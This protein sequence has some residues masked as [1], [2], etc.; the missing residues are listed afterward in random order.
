MSEDQQS[1]DMSEPGSMKNAIKRLES[2]PRPQLES[3][4]KA[5][6]RAMVM[7][8]ARKQDFAPQPL[9]PNFNVIVRWA[10]VASLVLFVMSATGVSA[11]L[12]SV[13]GDVLYPLKQRFEQLELSFTSTAGARAMQH[14]T[15]AQR[16]VDEVQILLQ[17]EQDVESTAFGVLDHLIQAAIIANNDNTISAEDQGKMLILTTD[18]TNQLNTLLNDSGSNTLLESVLATENSGTLLLAT[19]TP[20]ATPTSTDSPTPTAMP[21]NTATPTETS[22]HTPTASPS[23]T[24]EVSVFIEGRI[25]AI[26][27]NIIVIYGIDHPV[28]PNNPLLDSIEIGDYVRITGDDLELIVTETPVAN[29][30][31]PDPII[32]DENA[33]NGEQNATGWTDDGSCNNPPPDHAPAHG[34]RARCEGQASPG[35]SGNQGQGNGGNNNGNGQGNNGNNGRGNPN[36]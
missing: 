22:T 32:A 4:K 2:A 21:T 36:K 23:P 18:L 6:I 17:R 9:R 7:A 30:V 28:N 16:R 14:M 1:P 8:R 19:N 33:P 34:W 26:N 12:A 11:T 24:M 10:A 15:H 5:E 29:I 3:D 20:T 27:S 31:A 35:N 25:E 13:P